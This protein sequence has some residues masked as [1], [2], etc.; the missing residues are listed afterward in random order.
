[1]ISWSISSVDLIWLRWNSVKILKSLLPHSTIVSFHCSFKCVGGSAILRG[2]IE[3][4]PLGTK[5][6]AAQC[7]R[8]SYLDTAF[9]L[10]F[11]IGLSRVDKFNSNVF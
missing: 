1:M 2:T 10:S 5:S 8:N 11:K 4:T 7:F 3:S 9:A 6:I